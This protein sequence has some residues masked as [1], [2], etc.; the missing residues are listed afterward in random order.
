MTDRERIALL[1]DH[2]STINEILIARHIAR[3]IRQ[4]QH[5]LAHHLLR[6]SEAFQ[7]D[8]G[9]LVR[10]D[11]GVHSGCLS[12][13]HVSWREGVDADPVW[14]PFGGETFADVGHGRFG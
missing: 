2:L 14:G 13:V 1:P 4:Q 11:L 3:T 12:G 5:R 10:A 6:F 7:R 9:S 8:V